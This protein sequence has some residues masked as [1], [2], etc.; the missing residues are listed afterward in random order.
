MYWNVSPSY[1]RYFECMVSFNTVMNTI[2]CLIIKNYSIIQLLKSRCYHNENLRRICIRM[3]WPTASG[4]HTGLF[5]RGVES[6]CQSYKDLVKLKL[7]HRT[8]YSQGW[9]SV[10]V[11]HQECITLDDMDHHPQCIIYRKRECPTSIPSLR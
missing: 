4:F 3:Q 9:S 6:M 7:K 2:L 10:S 8:N 11:R 1:R 5:V